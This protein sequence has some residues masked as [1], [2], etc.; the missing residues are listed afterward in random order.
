MEYYLSTIVY[1]VDFESVI[2]IVSEE[3]KTEGFGILTDIDMKATLKKKLDQDIPEYR[4]LGACNPPFAFESLQLE[5]KIGL[6]L[7]CNVIVQE[8]EEHI[9]VSAIDPVASMDSIKNPELHKVADLVRQKLLK[10]IKG[11][12][13]HSKENFAKI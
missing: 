6:M 2:D 13:R 10:V 7:P 5:D 11:V 8:K 4:I 12:N 3:L 9:E 1:D